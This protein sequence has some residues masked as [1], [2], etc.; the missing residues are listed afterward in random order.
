VAPQQFP[1]FFYD[2]GKVVTFSESV[3]TLCE[4]WIIEHIGNP[5]GKITPFLVVVERIL[6]HEI[7]ELFKLVKVVGSIADEPGRTGK[8]KSLLRGQGS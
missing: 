1:P 5:S 2:I 6:G 7:E 8:M 4:L 3:D